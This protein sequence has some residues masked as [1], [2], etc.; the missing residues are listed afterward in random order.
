MGFTGKKALKWKVDFIKAFNLM[1]KTLLNKKSIEWNKQR[2]QGKLARKSETD[3]IKNFV[4]YATIQG[5]KN[6]NFYYKHLTSATYKALQ[7]IQH[8]KPKIRETLD[9]LELNQL[10]LAENIAMKS[11]EEN[12]KTGEHYKAIFVNVKNDIE[13]FASTLFLPNQK[14]LNK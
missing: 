1:E 10:L 6:A 7:L 12:M 13:R 4:D 3:V 9:M 11:L 14:Q 8:K 5:S 2:E